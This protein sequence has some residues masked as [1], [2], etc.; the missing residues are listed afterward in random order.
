MLVREPDERIALEEI[1]RHSWLL[2]NE[3]DDENGGS[4]F[5]NELQDAKY[6]LTTPLI[7]RQNL[8]E[9]ETNDIIEQMVRGE[10]ASREDIKK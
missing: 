9:T 7:K 1:A 6:V 8:N 4:D 3:N 5:G 2:R 10:V